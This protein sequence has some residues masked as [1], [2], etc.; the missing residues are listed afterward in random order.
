MIDYNKI[1][2][3]LI[4]EKHSCNYRYGGMVP[5]YYQEQIR[6][7]IALL[8]ACQDSQR[9]LT[10]K[11]EDVPATPYMVDQLLKM[12]KHETDQTKEHHGAKLHHD[13]SGTD[14]LTIDAGGLGALIEYYV[15]H[16][17]NI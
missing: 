2:S 3:E 13:S 8:L 1:I 15:T 11:A 7:V 17:S 5:A 6:E 12:W 4:D 9:D 14:V 16:K 10:M